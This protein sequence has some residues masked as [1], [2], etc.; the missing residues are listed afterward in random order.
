MIDE[1]ER[2]DALRA[3]IAAEC[4]ARF[5][6]DHDLGLAEVAEWLVRRRRPAVIA[7]LTELVD[8]VIEQLN[9]DGRAE[10]VLHARPELREREP[11]MRLTS[12]TLGVPLW[13]LL[14][15]DEETTAGCVLAAELV[16]RLRM[17]ESAAVL[18]AAE[19]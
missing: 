3:L 6:K 19:H 2:L 8:E 14:E 15:V 13:H 17:E 7:A 12:E 11:A 18:E 9:D 16:E 10:S 4:K 5:A 1:H